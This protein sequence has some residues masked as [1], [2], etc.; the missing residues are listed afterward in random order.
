[1]KKVFFAMALL[2]TVVLSGCSGKPSGFP[3]VSP[4]EITVTKGAEPIEGVEIALIPDTP[5]SGVIAGGVTDAMGKCVVQ[6]TYANFQAPGA[7]EGA[8]TVTL[9]KDPTPSKPELT[10]EEMEKMERSDIDKY[11]KERAAEIRSLP[12]IIPPNLTSMQ[13]SKVKANIPGDSAISVDVS[14]YK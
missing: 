6:T 3:K 5:I 13:T 14:Q 1:M 9:R 10:S 7:P 11:N 12:Q 8:F 2:A 4:C